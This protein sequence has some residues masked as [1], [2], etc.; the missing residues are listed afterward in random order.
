MGI[1]MG[2]YVELLIAR[3]QFDATGRPLWTDEILPPPHDPLPGMDRTD[4][5]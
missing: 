4:A 3:D 5:A 1:T 2:R